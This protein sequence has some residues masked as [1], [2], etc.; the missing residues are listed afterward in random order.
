MRK[1]TWVPYMGKDREGEI[2]RLLKLERRRRNMFDFLSGGF[3]RGYRTYILGGLLA[4]QAI[5]NFAVG[6]IT[7]TE[8]SAELPDILAGLGLMALRAGVKR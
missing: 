2:D 3:L 4:L 6:D 5:A 1:P 8:L 7:L